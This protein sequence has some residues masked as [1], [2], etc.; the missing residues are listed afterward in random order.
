VDWQ[1]FLAHFCFQMIG[2]KMVFLSWTVVCLGLDQETDR[3]VPISDEKLRSKA[4]GIS[5]MPTTTI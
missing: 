5:A 4:S 3:Y 1:D 2:L